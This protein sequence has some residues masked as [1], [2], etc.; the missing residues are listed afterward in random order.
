MGEHM[1]VYDTVYEGPRGK[2][3]PGTQFN[4]IDVNVNYIIIKLVYNI[5]LIA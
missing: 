3:A 2:G 5:S 4:I 1:R